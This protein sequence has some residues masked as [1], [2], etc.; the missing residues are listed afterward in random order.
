MDERLRLALEPVGDGLEL[1]LHRRRHFAAE[2][3]AEAVL[4]KEAALPQPGLGTELLHELGQPFRGTVAPARAE[5]VEL[6]E[7]LY[8]AHAVGKRHLARFSRPLHCQRLE[9]RPIGQYPRHRD[10]A[11]LQPLGLA[12]VERVLGAAGVVV[13]DRDSVAAAEE[14]AVAPANAEE[15]DRAIAPIER[16]GKLR[17]VEKGVVVAVTVDIKVALDGAGVGPEHPLRRNRL[18]EPAVLHRALVGVYD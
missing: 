1:G 11:F 17:N 3:G 12:G 13:D 14:R 6:R 8:D 18:H 7:L 16:R 10:A 9:I 5:R 4:R 15:H 2:A